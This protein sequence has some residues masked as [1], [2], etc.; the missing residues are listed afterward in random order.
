MQWTK[1]VSLFFTNPNC[2]C[3]SPY[4]VDI[5]DTAS[6]QTAA[7]LWCDSPTSAEATY[8]DIGGWNTGGVESFEKTF[9][10]Y[11]TNGGICSSGQTFNADISGWD[12]SGVTT[13]SK[14]KSGGGRWE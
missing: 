5:T 4:T 12:V 11:A 3:I 6:L 7:S 14:S 1:P 13:L 8:G 10:Y 9:Y 2:G